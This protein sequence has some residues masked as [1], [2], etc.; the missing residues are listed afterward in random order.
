MLGGACSGAGQLQVASQDRC[1]VPVVRGAVSGVGPA[2][3]ALTLN[4]VLSEGWTPR[5]PHCHRPEIPTHVWTRGRAFSF[6][7]GPPAN[8]GL[9]WF[10]GSV[11]SRT[12]QE[13]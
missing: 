2:S 11:Y 3:W 6:C 10:A 7:P 9:R 13:R 4:A 8:W 12:Q 1:P 5:L